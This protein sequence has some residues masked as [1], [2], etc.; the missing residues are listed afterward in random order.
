MYRMTGFTADELARS[1]YFH[2]P[3]HVATIIETV[4]APV[5][6]GALTQLHLSVR[7]WIAALVLPALAQLVASL[8]AAPVGWWRYRQDVRFGFSTQGA[9][10][11]VVDIVKE[12]LVGSIVTVIAM[13]PLFALAHWA[14]HSWV[15]GAALG[16]AALVFILGFLAPIVLEPIFNKFAPLADGELAER[17]HALAV[18]AGAPV[19]EILV[20]DASRRTTRTNA[21]VSGVGSTRRI[22][23]W[24]TL[25]A[26]SADQIAVVL[27]HELGHRVRRHIA[28]FTALGMSGAAFYVV[29]L[30]VL[31]PHP[32]PHDAAFFL[33]VA[34]FLDV[35]GRPFLAA[36]SRRF[37]RAADRFSLEQTRDRAAYDAL[38]HD[39]AVTNL[40]ELE[41]P[42]WLYL[43]RFTHPTPIERLTA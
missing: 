35:A 36:L 26:G 19:R 15:W 18:Q 4:A 6:L 30:R 14:P 23:L 33:L 32:V 10:D 9:R 17:L 21:Y 13:A 29:V 42:R 40:S 5:A 43:W 3:R 7:W 34:V 8:V 11:K 25:L 16:A 37:E 20:A 1:R 31:R 41:P 12:L 38:H 27:A 24:D 2:R 28:A 39:L 22:V